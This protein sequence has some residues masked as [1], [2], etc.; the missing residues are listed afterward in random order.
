MVTDPILNSK[1]IKPILNIIERAYNSFYTIE[2]NGVFLM[3]E[4]KRIYNSNILIEDKMK[5]GFEYLKSCM[6]NKSNRLK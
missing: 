2:Q 6:E 5:N 4:L 1:E 3:D